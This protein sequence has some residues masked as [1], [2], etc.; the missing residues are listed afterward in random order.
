[1][2]KY[3]AHCCRLQP[4]HNYASQNKHRL[5]MSPKGGYLA[6]FRLT[7]STLFFYSVLGMANYSMHE[8]ALS[9]MTEPNR[10]D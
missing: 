7:D 3:N 9:L 4:E 10:S 1:M 6:S 2:S 8:F 5:P